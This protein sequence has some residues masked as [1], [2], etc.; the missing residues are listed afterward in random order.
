MGYMVTKQMLAYNTRFTFLEACRHTA[1][2][3]ELH[4][5]SRPHFKCEFTRARF[6]AEISAPV[7][8]ISVGFSGIHV[9]TAKTTPYR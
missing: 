7:P 9:P 2:S 1:W 4:P 6:V 8:F 3:L 5:S